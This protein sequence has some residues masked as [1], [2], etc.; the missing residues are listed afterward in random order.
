MYVD[1]CIYVNNIEHTLFVLITTDKLNG[2]VLQE[3]SHVMTHSDAEINGEYVWPVQGILWPFVKYLYM[4]SP[5]T[6]LT[7]LFLIVIIT[8]VW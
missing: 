5:F 6:T 4:A 7:I 1:G 8:A 3:V 2:P